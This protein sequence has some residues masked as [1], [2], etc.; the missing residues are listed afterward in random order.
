MT[1]LRWLGLIVSTLALAV[2]VLGPFQG[3]ANA[4]SQVPQAALGNAIQGHLVATQVRN[5]KMVV[6]PAVTCTGSGCDG[7]YPQDVGCN[8]DQ[9]TIATAY[10]GAYTSAT[11]SAHVGLR[12][13]LMWSQTCQTNWTRLTWLDTTRDQVAA[14]IVRGDGETHVNFNFLTSVGSQ[15][16]SQ[17]IY[18]PSDTG[19][20][21]GGTGGSFTSEEGD[22]IACTPAM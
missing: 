18:A 22:W 16:N 1:K 5:P 4:S 21:C 7:F 20:A 6:R 10:L 8:A 17:M 2:L 19:R 14:V 9:K 12:V 13:E 15:L 3:S 11:N